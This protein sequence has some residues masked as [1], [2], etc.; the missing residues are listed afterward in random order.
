MKSKKWIITSLF[1]GI[2]GLIISVIFTKNWSLS[3]ICSV[4]IFIIVLL[5]NPTKLFMKAFWIILTMFFT[6]NK[7]FFEIVGSIFEI[8]FTIGS[9]NIGDS[10]SIAL[11]L[12]AGLALLFFFLERNGTLIYNKRR[13]SA[14]SNSVSNYKNL[15]NDQRNKIG[16]IGDSNKII[17]KNKR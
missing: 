10:V 11:I 8:D 14:K 6:L 5:N 1:A 16:N 15:Q 9:N 12:L 3:L 4:A 13:K 7:F 2:F 17:Q